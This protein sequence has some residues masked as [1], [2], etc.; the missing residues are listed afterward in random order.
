MTARFFIPWLA[1]YLGRRHQ[2]AGDAIDYRAQ[3]NR[4]RRVL[5]HLPSDTDEATIRLI[6]DR[7]ART[8][9][10]VDAAYLVSHDMPPHLRDVISS[11]NATGPI[12]SFGP[13][14]VGFFQTL[15]REFLHKLREPSFDLALDFSPRFNLT[16][17]HAL[18]SCGAAI[19]AGT[20]SGGQDGFHNLLIR[21]RH[22]RSFPD[23]LFELLDRLKA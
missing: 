10:D 1:G 15:R 4:V 18:S 16:H 17:A 11:C 22:P 20:L 14:D 21:V 5:I 3:L 9:G 12:H 19:V 6:H 7:M 2:R 13:D 8:F 23:Q